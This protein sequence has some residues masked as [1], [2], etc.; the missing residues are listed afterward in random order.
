MFSLVNI[1]LG[2]L[3]LVLLLKAGFS[4]FISLTVWFGYVMLLMIPWMAGRSWQG[5]THS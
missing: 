5:H 4:Y 3:V 1:L 2:F